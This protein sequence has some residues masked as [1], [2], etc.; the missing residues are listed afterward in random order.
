MMMTA[1]PAFAESRVVAIADVHGDLPAF[2]AMLRDASVVDAAGEWIAGDD[3]V[4]QLGDLIDRGPAMKSALD[5]VMALERQAAARGGRFVSILG[6]HEVMNLVGD[7]RY[8]APA[9]FAEFAGPGS[10]K[11]QAEAW[12]EVAKW[13]RARAAARGEAEPVLGSA[14]KKAWLATHP[15]GYVEQRAAFGPTGEYGRWLRSRPALFVVGDTLFLHGSISAERTSRTIEAIERQVREEIARFDAL[16]EGFV[17]EGLLLPYLDLPEATLALRAELAALD[18]TE[19]RERAAAETAGAAYAPPPGAAE[20]RA[21]LERFLGWGD[22]SIFTSE[23]PLWCRE[24]A[25]WEDDRLAAELPKLRAELGVERFVVGH[26]PGPK[27]RIVDRLGGAIY[28]ADTGLNTSYVKGGRGSALE[29]AGGAVHAIYAG[30]ERETLHAAPP[31]A[32]GENRSHPPA[33]AR[34]MAA[35]PSIG[36]LGPDGKQLPFASDAELLAFLREAEVVEVKDIGEGITRPRRL[37]L[38]RGGVRARAVF[39]DVH[40]EK[41]IANVG[42]GRREVNFRDHFGF[43]PAAYRLS[44][45][46]GLDRVPPA[47]LRRWDG[48]DGSVQIWIEKARTEGGR[49]EEGLTPPSTVRWKRQLQT[50]LAWDSLIGNTDRNQGNILFGPDWEIWFIDHTRSF[51]QSTDLPDAGRIIWCSRRLLEK[52]R[53]VSDDAIREAARGLLTSGEVRGVIA[54]RAKLLSHIERLI[55]EKGE[56]AVL[57]D[58]PI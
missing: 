57:F 40:Q 42:G 32:A 49:K 50:M 7:L 26:T 4:V 41:R 54:R 47:D 46:F 22:W 16:F 21:R 53:S 24:F 37:T 25:Q 12:R 29:F 45:L 23:G 3:T 30:G 51:R 9:S 17:A 56:A 6:N 8:V 44:Q 39:R 5:R 35:T 15:P 20:R 1:L 36:F 19:A 43:E 55:A 11:R 18:A 38:E 34:E 58:E 27:G 2:E 28:L 48:S 31:T 10:E 33:G 13:Q 14:E 52:L